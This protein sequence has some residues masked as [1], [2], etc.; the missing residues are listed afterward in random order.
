MDFSHNNTV[1]WS[2]V[3]IAVGILHMISSIFKALQGGRHK[4]VSTL[5]F[6]LI[7]SL[8]LITCGIL[9]LLGIGSFVP[10]D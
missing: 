5:I 7:I 3:F 10:A 4:K 6:N 1:L 8:M 2:V 9:A